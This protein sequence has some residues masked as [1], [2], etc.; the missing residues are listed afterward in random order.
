MKLSGLL[1]TIILLTFP[2]ILSAQ[3]VSPRE[4]KGTVKSDK[5]ELLEGV[6]I[7]VKGS[8]GGTTTDKSGNFSLSISGSASLL[9]S[10]AGFESKEV[11]AKGDETLTIVLHQNVAQLDEIVVTAVGIKNT[12]RSINY[13]LQHL[14]ASEITSTKEVN[15]VSA[16]SGKVAGVQVNNSSGQPGGSATI[17]IRGSASALG[18]NSPLFVFDGMPID[19]SNVGLSIQNAN[20]IVNQSNRAIDLNPNDIESI[21]VLKGPAAAALYGIRA[22]NG[23]VIITGKKGTINKNKNSF[24]VSLYS[25]LTFESI[26]RRLQPTQRIFGQGVNGKYVVPGQNGSE[27]AWGPLL[28]TITY[29]STPSKWDVNG[30]IVGQSDPTSNGI[31]V[32]RYDNIENFFQQGHTNDNSVS[33]TGNTEKFGYYFSLGRLYQKGIA[34]TTD[35]FRNTVRFGT[36]F[37]ANDKLDFNV[38]I[39][40]FNS[41]SHNRLLPGGAPAGVMRSLINTPANFDI[42]NALKDPADNILSYTFADGTQRAYA[43]GTRGFD[44]PFWSLNNNPHPDD[45]NRT[46]LVGETNY[47]LLDWLSATFRVGTD[48]SFEKRMSLFNKGSVAFPAGVLVNYSFFNRDFNTDLYLTANTKLSKSLGLRVIAGHNY[49]DHYLNATLNQGNN[50]NLPGFENISNASTFNIQQNTTKR[51]LVAGYGSVELD[52]K[53]WLILNLTGRNEWT[54]TLAT[55]KNSFFYPSASI[56]WVINESLGW[57]TAPLDYLKVRAS[58]ARVGNDASPYSLATYYSSTT[59]G[60]SVQG[61]TLNFPF[62]GLAGYSLNGNLGNINLKPEQ[63]T[64]YEAGLETWLFKNRLGIELTVYKNESR[65]QILPVSIPSSTGFTNFITNAGLISNKGLEAIIT[66]VILR[67]SAFEWTSVLN[68]SHNK[69]MVN[70][71]T[72]NSSMITLM[73]TNGGA[74]VIMPGQP[75]SVIYGR[76]LTTNES[77]Q[78]IIDDRATVNGATNANYGFPIADASP[79]VIGDPNPLWNAGIRNT[80]RYK[81]ISLS[82]LFD[83]RYKFD[84][85]NSTLA[86]MVSNAV[87]EETANRY[88][89]IVFEGVGLT[90][91]KTNEISVVPGEAWYRSTINYGSVYV[92]KDLW[93]IRLRD[94]NISYSL[95]TTWLEKTK[96][97]ALELTLT[98]R[99]LF[100]STN[101]SGSDPD[102]NLRGGFTNGFGSDFF[103]YPTTKSYGVALRVSF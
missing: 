25:S 31:P 20:Q 83:H 96:I 38:S 64:S 8:Q 92:E 2:H 47:K 17:R 76:A 43:G 30:A 63:I 88:D 48:L 55:D 5:G 11:L 98:G 86:Q 87:A 73:S 22:S 99:N 94:V 35:F 44:S 19:N 79:S 100:L 18:D 39:N 69:S 57:Y 61:Q 71:L 14:K 68:F 62:N 12:K 40:Y 84:L 46:V 13:S 32:N 82:F 45:I 36:T 49:F 29:S 72:E 60:G 97:S 66:A 3:Q 101:Y 75:F 80:F 67:S 78:T 4:V 95:P 15:I 41:G 54:S 7:T 27:D 51:R 103:N 70:S 59:L 24:R 53:K 81:N 26:A 42:T 52:Y 65:N 1:W 6:S 23:A 50:L 9:F 56:G 102:V 16:L 74:Q 10:Y 37:R 58:V 34:P 90:S 28:D 85:Y 91:G 77:G 93:W 33:V 89:N 21:S